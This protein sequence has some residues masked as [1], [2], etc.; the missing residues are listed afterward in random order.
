MVKKGI[1]VLVGLFLSAGAW[2]YVGPGVGLTM[3]GSLLGLLSAIGLSLF[4]VVFRPIKN[5][6]K[7]ITGKKQ[8]VVAK[9][10]AATK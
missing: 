4:L 2:A 6:F 1:F 9:N 3:I 8:E 5:L 10:K 7:K